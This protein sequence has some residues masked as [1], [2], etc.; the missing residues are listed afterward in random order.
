ML[1][2]VVG[3]MLN[4]DLEQ[5]CNHVDQ[6][7]SEIV[8]NHAD[9]TWMGG[10]LET[11]FAGIQRFIWDVRGVVPAQTFERVSHH[12]MFPHLPRALTSLF[13]FTF[14]PANPDILDFNTILTSLIT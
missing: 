9:I 7:A 4:L 2:R 8:A 3:L 12:L 14:L 6:P 10:R 11:R 13:I 5:N 1:D